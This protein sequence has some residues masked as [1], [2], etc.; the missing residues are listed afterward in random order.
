MK[1]SHPSKPPP[2]PTFRPPPPPPPGASPSAGQPPSTSPAAKSQGTSV[3]ASEPRRNAW[4]LPLAN[5]RPSHVAAN[6]HGSPRQAAHNE[7][8][9]SSSD[10]ML[11]CEGASHGSGLPSDYGNTVG[12][13]SSSSVGGH[14]G[15]VAEA[16]CSSPAQVPGSVGQSVTAA[17]AAAAVGL[18][19][20][21]QGSDQY[22]Q[23]AH[24]KAQIADLQARLA[25]SSCR[26]SY[27]P[28]SSKSISRSVS[29]IS[30]ARSHCCC[31]VH[32][33]TM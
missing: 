4:A 1:P 7:S 23:E 19:G 27:A 17:A 10:N 26:H 25:V 31:F 15:Y 32:T 21:S 18:Q 29:R 14:Q 8:S 9:A 16:A 5:P 11:S 6:S 24:H 20:S 13:K 28:F 2:P 33:Y 30:C 22:P 12:R 3:P